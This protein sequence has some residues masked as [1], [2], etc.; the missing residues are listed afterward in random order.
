MAW[1]TAIGSMLRSCRARRTSCSLGGNALLKCGGASGINIAAVVVR[2]FQRHALNIGDRS[3]N[4]TGGATK[5]MC[6]NFTRSVGACAWSGNV[7][8]KMPGN[9]SSGWTV[10]WARGVYLQTRG[11]Q[12]DAD[13][14]ERRGRP[15]QARVL[16]ASL[17][18]AP[19][20]TDGNCGRIE[21]QGNRIPNKTPYPGH[22]RKTYTLL[23][24]PAI[25]SSAVMEESRQAP[26]RLSR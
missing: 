22:R 20:E 13:S 17:T 1:D 15:G 19:A 14:P 12:S 3:W 23:R 9:S 8:R 4:A 2:A 6:A 18:A 25:N 24:A 7:K 11:G 26:P 21:P 5:K 10:S 16:T